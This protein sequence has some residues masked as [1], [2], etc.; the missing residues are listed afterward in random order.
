MDNHFCISVEI[1]LILKTKMMNKGKKEI[2]IKMII[3]CFCLFCENYMIITN[4]FDQFYFSINEQKKT[5]LINEI[6]FF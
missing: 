2:K 6:A 3:S 4:I 5:F 1:V